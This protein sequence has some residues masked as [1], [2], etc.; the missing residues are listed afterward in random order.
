MMKSE[1]TKSIRLIMLAFMFPVIAEA[2]AAPDT[3]SSIEFSQRVSNLFVTMLNTMRVPTES[4]KDGTGE[5]SE[6]VT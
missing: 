2:N 5:L 6:L 4:F 1:K 3:Q